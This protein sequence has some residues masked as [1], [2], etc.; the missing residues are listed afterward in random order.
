MPLVLQTKQEMKRP[1]AT[2]WRKCLL[3]IINIV[4]TLAM[5]SLTFRGQREHVGNGDWHGGNFLA[6]VAMQERFDH[7]PP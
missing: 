6:L 3:Q 4:M 5:M 1:E 2:L 7:T